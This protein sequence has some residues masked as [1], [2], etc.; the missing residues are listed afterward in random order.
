MAGT[1]RVPLYTVENNLR[2]YGYAKHRLRRYQH[3]AVRSGE[4]RGFLA[5]SVASV[6]M[7]RQGVFIYLNA[8]WDRDPPLGEEL[9]IVFG[10]CKQTAVTADHLM[11]PCDSGCQSDDDG[12][13]GA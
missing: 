1:L 6:D 4:S 8:Q 12:E 10:D 11:V 7:L 5:G 13:G 3:M 9:E 2:I